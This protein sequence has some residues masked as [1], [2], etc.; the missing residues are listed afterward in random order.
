MAAP[1]FTSG[2]VWTGDIF[3]VHEHGELAFTV[4]EAGRQAHG[5][6]GVPTAT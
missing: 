2:T 1:N 4:A 6:D 5:D 3:A